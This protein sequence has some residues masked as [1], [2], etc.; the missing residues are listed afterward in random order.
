MGIS[1][2]RVTELWIVGIIS[3]SICSLFF[4]RPSSFL[5]FIIF[6]VVVVVEQAAAVAV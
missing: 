5:S 4:A 2:Q 3:S 6:D 1:G